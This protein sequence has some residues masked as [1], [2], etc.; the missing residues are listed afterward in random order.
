MH[1]Q[2]NKPKTLKTAIKGGFEKISNHHIKRLGL[3]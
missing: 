1:P 2:I 3:S